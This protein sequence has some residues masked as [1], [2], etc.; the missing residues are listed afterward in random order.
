MK[1]VTNRLSSSFRDPSGFLFFENDTLFRSV[2]RL[3]QQNYDHL[4]QSGLYY[5][6]VADDLLIPH[7][8]VQLPAEASGKQGNRGTRCGIMSPYSPLQN[9]SAGNCP[10][11]LLSLRMVLQPVEGC[12]AGA[13]KNPEAGARLQ[14][15][16]ERCER[17]QHAISQGEAHFNRHAFLRNLQRKSTLGRLSSVLS[18][19]PGAAFTDGIP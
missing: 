17:I 7:K 1:A 12:G 4:I 6:L 9:H 10:L 19:F 18:A 13:D 3:Y 15:V 16:P 8:E 11:H 2:S 5:K 14:H